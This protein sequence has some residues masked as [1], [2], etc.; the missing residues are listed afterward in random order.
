MGDVDYYSRSLAGER[1]RKCYELAPSR[2]RQYLE[3]E[4]GF[5]A[6][7]I[8][9]DSRVLELGCGYG[10]VL[11]EL[12]GRASCLFG[13]DTSHESL[14][15]AR[16]VLGPDSQCLLAQMNATALGIR[17]GQF[18]VV[19][20]IQNGISAFNVDQRCLLAEAT[21][22]TRSGGTVIVSSYSPRFWRH[23]LEWFRIQSEHG[24]LGEIDEAATRD[25]VIACKDGFRSGTLEPDE[26]RALVRPFGVAPTITEVDGSSICSEFV[27]E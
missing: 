5:V 27:V 14:R 10:R 1:L 17:D 9:H 21:R 2:V 7:R 25:G 3:A 23:R 26:L 4:M 8:P 18:D 16:E 6:E 12:L 11:G 24:L 22:V 19:F 13:I 15:L 20:C